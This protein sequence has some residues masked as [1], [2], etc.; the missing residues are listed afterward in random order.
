MSTIDIRPASID[1]FAIAVEWAAAEGW[2]PGLDDIEVFHETDPNGF[3][4]G[5]QDGQPISAIS[6]V[7]YGEQYGFLGFYIVHPNFRGTGAG[8][9]TWKAGMAHLEGRTV[10]LDGVVAQQTNYERSGFA[11]ASRNVR[12]TGV[13]Q[14]SEH[15]SS[16]ADIRAALSSDEDRLVAYDAPFFAGPRASFIA[17]W[18]RPAHPSRHTYIA[19][20]NGQ[21]V[22]YGTIR[23]CRNGYKIGPLFADDQTVAFDL[24]LTL[25]RPLPFGNEVS[26]DTPQSNPEATHLAESLGLKP[27]FE[28]ARMYR[29]AIPDIQTERT[30]GVTTFE[31][32]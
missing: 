5:W 25:Y 14:F 10:G 20:R 26:L 17:D 30:Y 27:S 21:I 12:Y 28:T 18:T 32:G 2:N 9:L 16:N 11:N 29:G 15:Q 24:F 13:P 22:G 1:E 3:L 6:V 31:L 19:Y 23:A 8:L 7:R 4:M